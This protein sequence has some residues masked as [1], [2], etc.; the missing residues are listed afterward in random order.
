MVRLMLYKMLYKMRPRLSKDST[1]AKFPFSASYQR[2]KTLFYLISDNG[3]LDHLV[4]VVSAGLLLILLI[5]KLL[6]FLFYLIN[7]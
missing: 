6:F 7:T 2:Y 1:K 4:G 3:N 5:V